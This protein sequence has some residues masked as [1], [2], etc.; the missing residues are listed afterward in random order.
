[1]GTSKRQIPTDSAP[2]RLKASL[3][4]SSQMQGLWDSK[5]D[6]NHGLQ[7]PVESNHRKQ[8]TVCLDKRGWVQVWQQS[9]RQWGKVC[10]TWSSSF[11]LPHTRT[12]RNGLHWSSRCPQTPW[13]RTAALQQLKRSMRTKIIHTDCSG[14]KKQAKAAAVQMA[15]K[16]S[17][18]L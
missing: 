15:G 10:L 7:Y 17:T 2:T 11:L 13:R 14:E 18:V 1:M 5:V 12:L 4:S 9:E 16:Q 8:C 3:G 6:Q